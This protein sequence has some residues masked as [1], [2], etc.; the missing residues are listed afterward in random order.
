MPV[1]ETS[2]QALADHQASGEAEKVRGAIVG[3]LRANGRLTRAELADLTRRPM[4][5][6]SGRVGDF[7]EGAVYDGHTI[8]K[9]GRKVCSIGGK[10][11]EA[12]EAKELDVESC[13][14]LIH[15]LRQKLKCESAKR[16]GIERAFKAVL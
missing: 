13:I 10:T 4:H 3:L 15:G 2:K 7:F 1:T 6:I 16:Q 8:I 14:S 11:V 12:L 5:V 9:S